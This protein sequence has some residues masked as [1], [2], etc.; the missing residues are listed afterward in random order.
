[1]DF[2]GFLIKAIS[3]IVVFFGLLIFTMLT[4]WGERKVASYMQT[5]IGPNQA[6]PGGVLITLAD[7]IKLFFKESIVPL[8]ADRIVYELAPILAMVPAFLAF[9][10][11]PF[12]PGFNIIGRFVPMQIAN[13]NVGLLWFLAM[14]SIGVYS[15]MLAG[16]SSGSKYPLLGG[17]RA[18]AQ[19][20][21]YEAAMS[22]AMVPVVILAGSMELQDIV[23]AQG[24]YW[25]FIV[26]LV[27]P[28]FFFFI[29]GLAETNRP[30]FDL[31]EAETELVGGFHTEYSGIRFALFYLAEYI[32]VITISA[33]ATTF[34]LGG[35]QGPVFFGLPGLWGLI[36]FLLKTSILIFI[37]FWIRV[38]VPRIRYDK[39][40]QFG[41]KVLI[42][43]N[44]VYT[45]VIAFLVA[46]QV[47]GHLPNWF[48]GR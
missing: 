27:I 40:M 36:W 29:A 44:L 7:G 13:L 42:P 34:F 12:G 9:A 45:M 35:W 43:I 48:G 11:I 21:S 22:L 15:S 39:L 17:V 2:W 3:V 1:M 24:T 31:V 14:S 37:F 30:P 6:G 8:R 10:I 18:S 28:F 25:W 26:P 4:V 23:N 38:T 47:E 19:V 33:L 32:N 16:W 20:I 41:W 46:L 5:R